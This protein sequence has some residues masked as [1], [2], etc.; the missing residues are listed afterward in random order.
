[1]ARAAGIQV[2]GDAVRWLPSNVIAMRDPTAGPITF[3]GSRNW[4]DSAHRFRCSPSGQITSYEWTFQDG[5][6]ATSSSGPDSDW[7]YWTGKPGTKTVTVRVTG[8]NGSDQTSI[9]HTVLNSA[10]RP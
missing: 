3:I 1:M 2:S 8:P 9:Q 6:P 5:T 7:V 10:I 4:D